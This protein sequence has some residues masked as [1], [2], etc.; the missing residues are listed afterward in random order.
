[1]IRRN[2]ATEKCSLKSTS[3]SLINLYFK[4]FW[5]KKKK[6]SILNIKKLVTW[7]TGH[8]HRCIYMCKICS[9]C[10]ILFYSQRSRILAT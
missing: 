6:E 4:E 10:F 3:K 7:K 5:E 9:I 1:M 2:E 8:T